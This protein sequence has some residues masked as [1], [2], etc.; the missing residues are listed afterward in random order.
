[1]SRPLPHNE[2]LG[3]AR[4]TIRIGAEDLEVDK[5]HL[6]HPLVSVKLAFGFGVSGKDDIP[7][8]AAGSTR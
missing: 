6:Q 8:G 4:Q 7:P 3:A 2:Q 1:M 5:L